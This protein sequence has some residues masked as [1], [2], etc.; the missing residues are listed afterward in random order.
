MREVYGERVAQTLK[1]ERWLKK[2]GKTGWVVFTKDRGLRD[3]R[4][5]EHR[6]LVRWKVKAFVLPSARLKEEAQIARYVDNRYRIAMKAM[7]PGPFT[8]LVEKKRVT[9]ELYP[10]KPRGA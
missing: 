6:A 7:K 3:P 8:A 4:T 2:C 5:N 9:F 10:P 1:D